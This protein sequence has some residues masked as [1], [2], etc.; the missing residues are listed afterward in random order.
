MTF[1]EAITGTIP[2]CH[3]PEIRKKFEVAVVD[4]DAGEN[5]LGRLNEHGEFIWSGLPCTKYDNKIVWDWTHTE[6]TMLIILR[7]PARTNNAGA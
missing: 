7:T 5:K 6:R 4:M 3:Y 2:T 1:K